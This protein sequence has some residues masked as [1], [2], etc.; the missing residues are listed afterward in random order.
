[1]PANQ[2]VKTTLLSSPH[3]K[4]LTTEREKLFYLVLNHNHV[5][6]ATGIYKFYS[7]LAED[8]FGHNLKG[9]PILPTKD[10]P[11]LIKF[12]IKKKKIKYNAKNH[13][14]WVIDY[15]DHVP[16]GNG[17]PKIIAERIL[18]DF[19]DPEITEFESE[20]IKHNKKMILKWYKDKKEE[21]QEKAKKTGKTGVL[22]AFDK[23]PISTLLTAMTN[24]F[25]D[26]HGNSKADSHPDCLSKENRV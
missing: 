17:S 22:K 2:L 8:Y 26:S 5:I 4:S 3:F 15:Y 1:M 13:L 9:K 6:S 10:V 19:R 11:D 12:L 23:P 16:F 14:I 21:A 24:G 7:G 20:Y 25:F 18:K